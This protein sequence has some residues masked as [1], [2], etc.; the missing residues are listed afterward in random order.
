MANGI[1]RFDPFEDFTRL[2]R[3]MN[4]LFDDSFGTPTRRNRENVATAAWA[5]AVDVSED[6]NEIVL[7]AEVPGVKQDDLD[8]ELTGDTLTIKGEKKFE[9]EERKGNYVRV[10]RSY[11]SFQRS[12]NLAVP[13]QADKINATFK[14]GVLTVHLPKSEAT[15]PRKV[16]VQTS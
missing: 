4:R 9:D 16:L 14:D 2:Q 10:E 1:V 15:K 6:T 7:R 3:D 11:G 8:I 5:P 12:F 13:V